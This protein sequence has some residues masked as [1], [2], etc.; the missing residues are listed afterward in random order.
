M[1]GQR[2][3]YSLAEMIVVVLIIGALAF[4]A[5][6]RLN[7]AALY[8][9]QAHTF[10]KTIVTDLRRTRTLAIVNAATKRNGFTLRIDSSSYQIIDNNTPAGE[11][12]PNSQQTIPS[13]VTC[14]GGPDFTFGPLGNLTS[15][16][17]QLKVSDK[18]KSRTYTITIKSATGMVGCTG[19]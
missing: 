8:H 16:V 17:T 4:I 9:K 14:E 18:D 19:G 5:V 10:A 15:S 11:T 7:L 6:P 2:T 3:G 13:Q 1:T 12:V